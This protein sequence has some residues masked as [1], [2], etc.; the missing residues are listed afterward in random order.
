MQYVNYNQ[1]TLREKCHSKEDLTHWP[2]IETFRP[3]VIWGVF[4][5]FINMPWQCLRWLF[6]A[7]APFHKMLVCDVFQSLITRHSTPGLV[8][9]VAMTLDGYYGC[10]WFSLSL[11]QWRDVGLESIWKLQASRDVWRSTFYLE[12]WN[13]ADWQY[14]VD[15]YLS[16]HFFF[17]PPPNMWWSVCCVCLLPECE[18]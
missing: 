7:L 14:S 16:C 6:V 9:P 15:F 12:K 4:N 11:S 5:F 17:F 2:Y 1:E 8:D 18:L 3:W 13:F 10:S